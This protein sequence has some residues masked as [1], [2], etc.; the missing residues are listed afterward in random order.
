METTT[1]IETEVSY[2]DNSHIFGQPFQIIE[3]Y[4]AVGLEIQRTDLD[5]W[6]K[7]IRPFENAGIEF[8]LS[9]KKENGGKK[10]LK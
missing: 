8:I 1:G 5:E 10:C 6:I 3:S 7:R 2:S 9:Y 4:D